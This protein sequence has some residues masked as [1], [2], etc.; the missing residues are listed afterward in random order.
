[1]E[2]SF[3][4]A[5]SLSKS[6]SRNLWTLSPLQILLQSSQSFRSWLALAGGTLT[7][8]LMEPSFA[9]ALTSRSFLMSAVDESK[10]LVNDCDRN[11]EYEGCLEKQS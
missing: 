2:V 7:A 6:D 4:S 8:A 1:M 9:L 11:R 3:V 5:M 10:R